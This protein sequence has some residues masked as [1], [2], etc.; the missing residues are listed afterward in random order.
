MIN[1]NINKTFK[2]FLNSTKLASYR[3]SYMPKNITHN[4]ISNSLNK[5]SNKKFKPFRIS[6]IFFFL[7]IKSNLKLFSKITLIKPIIFKKW[8]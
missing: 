4:K 6:I 7:A 3:D 5:K 1:K 2:I 8:H